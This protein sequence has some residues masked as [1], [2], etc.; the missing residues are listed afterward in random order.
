MGQVCAVRYRV[1]QSCVLAKLYAT[2]SVIVRVRAV[3]LCV[4]AAYS[5][6]NVCVVACVYPRDDCEATDIWQ[7]CILIDILQHGW[8]L[9]ERHAV[10]RRC[11]AN[12]QPD[13]KEGPSPQTPFVQ[14]SP[15]SSLTHCCFYSSSN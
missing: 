6:Y 15:L 14:S 10:S 4:Y 1:Q 8:C 9:C 3:R 12:K 2:H 13:G 5:V 11:C 7:H